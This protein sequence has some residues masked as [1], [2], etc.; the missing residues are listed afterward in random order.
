[1]PGLHKRKKTLELKCRNH[2]TTGEARRK[3]QLQ[4]MKYS[5]SVKVSPASTELQETITS[6]FEALIQSVSEKIE[7]LLQAVNEKLEKQ[8]SIFSNMLHKTIDSIMQNMYKIIVQS[9]ETNT[10]PT[11][12]KTTKE[13]GS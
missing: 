1:M 9:L 4:N 12:K 5:E 2:I 11:R 6:K 7:G 10:S 3:F 8:T 13:F